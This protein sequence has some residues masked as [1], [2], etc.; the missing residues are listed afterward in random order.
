MSSLKL[1]E[2]NKE[3]ESANFQLPFISQDEMP[4]WSFCV[5]RLK[6]A[7]IYRKGWIFSPERLVNPIFL[8]VL[9]GLRWELGGAGLPTAADCRQINTSA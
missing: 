5:H 3:I 9:G 4:S 7:W 2:K 1:P 6:A 8:Y